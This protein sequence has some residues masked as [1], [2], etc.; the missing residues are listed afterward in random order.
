MLGAIA[1][2]GKGATWDMGHLG[3][4][5]EGGR[6]GP[7]G[8]RQSLAVASNGLF[9]TASNSWRGGPCFRNCS[10]FH[11]FSPGFESSKAGA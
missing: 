4:G 10:A 3:H 9:M 8:E 11:K 7:M 1:A 5:A 6:G 2:P